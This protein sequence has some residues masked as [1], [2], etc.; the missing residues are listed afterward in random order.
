MM[1][2][3]L[4]VLSQL[5]PSNWRYGLV[6]IAC[7]ASHM[8]LEKFPSPRPPCPRA[9]LPEV[10]VLIYFARPWSFARYKFLAF[11]SVTSEPYSRTT[12]TSQ[13]AVAQRQ[14]LLH[15]GGQSA[16]STALIRQH[17]SCLSY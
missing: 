15:E 1:N 16:R 13:N 5:V 12:E 10:G 7:S 2:S 17:I 6:K 4:A 14:L 9:W 8:M 11:Y 3:S